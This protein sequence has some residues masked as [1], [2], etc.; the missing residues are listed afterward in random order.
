[1]RESNDGFRIAEEDLRLRGPGEVLGQKQSGDPDFILADLA[2]HEEL[3]AL[4]RDEAH[5]IM[6]RNPELDGEEGARLKL[7]LA[8]FERDMAVTYLAG[9]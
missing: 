3:L 1:M 7:L 9:G 2:R 5:E 8:L 4:A 6:S